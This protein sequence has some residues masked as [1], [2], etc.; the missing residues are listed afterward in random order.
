MPASRWAPAKARVM[1]SMVAA[2]APRWMPSLV[3]PPW[4]SSRSAARASR[5]VCQ[6]RVGSRR[7]STEACT[8]RLRVEPWAVRQQRRFRLALDDDI[9]HAGQP[10]V[11]QKHL[12]AAVRTHQCHPYPAGAQSR[13][14]IGGTPHRTCGHFVRTRRDCPDHGQGGEDHRM[15]RGNRPGRRRSAC[16]VRGCYGFITHLLDDGA[17]TRAATASRVWAST[18]AGS[19]PTGAGLPVTGS[20]A[21]RVPAQ[22]P[23]R[24]S[25]SAWPCRAAPPRWLAPGH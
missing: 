10:C 23:V 25:G 6:A 20:D 15:L 19:A 24:E 16:G 1:M 2:M 22:M 4:V 18:S 21:A 9:E 11:S 8:T 17:P 14:Q 3:V 5:N 12:N 13:Q 7:A